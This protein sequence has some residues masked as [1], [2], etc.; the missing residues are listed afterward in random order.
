M[1]ESKTGPCLGLQSRKIL[2]E[3][4]SVWSSLEQE[5]CQFGWAREVPT[6]PAFRMVNAGPPDARACGL[7]FGPEPHDENF[8]IQV[9][10]AARQLLR[11][12][13][14]VGRLGKPG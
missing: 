7:W 2:L 4:G 3:Q 8:W 11:V 13:V 5:I 1:L 10:G 6:L 9:D 14:H 12:T